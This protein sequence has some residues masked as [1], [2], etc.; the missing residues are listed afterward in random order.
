MV[1]YNIQMVMDDKSITYWNNLLSQARDCFNHCAKRIREL[2]LPNSL[3]VVHKHLY[4]ELRG[5]YPLLPSQ[6][7]IKCQQEVLMTYKAI[8][9]NKHKNAETPQRKSLSMR[10]DKRLYTNLNLEGISITGENKGKRSRYCFVMYDKIKYL[11]TNYTTS[12]PL[13]FIRDGK[14]YL[15]I[16]FN[17]GNKPVLTDLSVGVDMGERRLF[18][19]SE[20]KAFRDKVYLKNR[21]KIR[22]QKRQLQSK[23]TKSAKRKLRKLKRR[24]QNLCKDMCYRAAKALINSTDAGIIVMENLKNLKRNTARDKEK[25]YMKTSHN[26]RGSQV[27]YYKFKEI[28]TYKAQL[29]GKQVETVNPSFTSQQDCRYGTTGC[30]KN[31]RF[32]CDDMVIFDSDWNAA[33]NI[34]KKGRHPFSNI[35]PIDGRLTFLNGRAQVNRPNVSPSY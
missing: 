35:L 3:K 9:S 11:L 25:R 26:R 29:A 31:R 20:G 10:L 22:F 4:H 32:Y 28:L 1:T 34:A 30:R 12:D 19:T 5:L 23:G 27:P 16:P 6:A 13:L 14:P 18:V 24:E 7:V 15:S 33:V 2:N 21:R 8:K 17:V